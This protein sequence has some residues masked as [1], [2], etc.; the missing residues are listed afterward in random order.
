M[1][2]LQSVQP[3]D[4]ASV[5][6]R[7]SWS[8]ISAGSILALSLCFLLTTLGTAVGVSVHDRPATSTIHIGSVAWTVMIVCASLFVGGMVTS[9]LTVGEN[10]TEAVLH[11]ILT[12]SLVVALFFVLGAAGIRNGFNVTGKQAQADVLN[13]PS[14]TGASE[15]TPNPRTENEDVT[16]RYIWYSF[17]GT[18]LSM[19][20]AALGAYLGAGP[21]FRV[22]AVP[23]VN[24]VGTS[25]TSR[26]IG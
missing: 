14:I 21:T 24:I 4:V 1:T 20:A 16:R 12:W 8:A 26:I 3:R 11:G 22:I 19:L 15:I 2:E 18:W 17:A 7:V 13:I 6:T 25:A 10:K 9:L 23:R 5:G